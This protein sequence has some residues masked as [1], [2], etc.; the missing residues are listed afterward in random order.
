MQQSPFSSRR[1]SSTRWGIGS[2]A[3]PPT[4]DMGVVSFAC[5]RVPYN[6]CKIGADDSSRLGDG[7][8]THSPRSL[9]ATRGFGDRMA[10]GGRPRTR[11][12]AELQAGGSAQG[13]PRSS[14]NSVP[15]ALAAS[16]AARKRRPADYGKRADTGPLG[17]H[18]CRHSHFR[19]IAAAPGQRLGSTASAS[20]E[21]P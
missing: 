13:Y 10:G 1:K 12:D 11:N 19:R 5:F 2:R 21:N 9:T 16:K 18:G 4:P 6:C 7:F 3:R 20:R 14:M 17:R 8:H 15:D